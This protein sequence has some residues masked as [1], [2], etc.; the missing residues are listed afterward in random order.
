M[1]HARTHTH[2]R[3]V[4]ILVSLLQACFLPV[5]ALVLVK[6]E[7]ADL[8]GSMD[9]VLEWREEVALMCP[10]A[11]GKNGELPTDLVAACPIDEDEPDLSTLLQSLTLSAFMRHAQRT[12]LHTG[13]I[14]AK[15]ALFSPLISPEFLEGQPNSPSWCR[16]S[17]SHFGELLQQICDSLG[18]SAG[19]TII[20][21]LIPTFSAPNQT[22]DLD[23]VKEL[24]NYGKVFSEINMEG[25]PSQAT[26]RESMKEHV[27][28]IAKQLSEG[29]G[30]VLSA[31][32]VHVN[33]KQDHAQDIVDYLRFQLE[34]CAGELFGL[35]HEKPGLLTQ[36][37]LHVL[38]VVA[39]GVRGD[40]GS[41]S[42]RPFL[43][44]GPA[45]E[46]TDASPDV[47]MF[48]WTGIAVDHFSHLLPWGMRPEEL[49]N[50][51]IKEIFGLQDESPDRFRRILA[52]AL[53]HVVPRFG[54]EPHHADSF[55]IIQSL[56]R[57][58]NSKP[59]LVSGI[60][61]VLAEQ[62]S[63]EEA[64]RFKS[65]VSPSHS[66]RKRAGSSSKHASKPRFQPSVEVAER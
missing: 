29:R 43:L 18:D 47:K 8:L 23:A 37:A 15:E 31:L 24:P 66:V 14:S 3:I 48:Q 7:L 52:D 19:H 30:R 38:A 53:P 16:S 17:K 5:V 63:L 60:R 45:T 12:S 9:E 22:L 4:H 27:E 13:E 49:L 21:L 39:H 65:Q 25:M 6:V 40:D 51:T 26:L 36:S 33:M 41:R 42:I 54:S 57:E 1:F 20:P 34:W 35:L 56:M 50:G 32:H 2:P 55:V 58:I 10:A 64:W 59:E 61:S 28:R 44:A 11:E 46:R 62:L